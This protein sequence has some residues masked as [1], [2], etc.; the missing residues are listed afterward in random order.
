MLV[1]CFNISVHTACV[2]HVIFLFLCF[3]FQVGNS[4]YYNYNLSVNGKT[5][6]HGDNY[7]DDYLTDLIVSVALA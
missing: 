6:S 7:P 1:M 4:V 2:F 5:E 3:S